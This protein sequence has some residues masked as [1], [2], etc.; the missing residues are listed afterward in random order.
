MTDSPEDPFARIRAEKGQGEPPKPAAS[1]PEG[2]PVLPVPDDA[3]PP[4]SRHSRHG[5]P[6]AIWTY[7]DGGGR[8]LGHVARFNLADGSKVVLPLTL[9]RDGRGLRWAWKA[10]A[11]PRPLYGLHALA[12]RP[13]APVLVVEGE[14]TTDAA[15]ERLA[16]FVA[17][18]WAGGSKA[19][20][21]ADWRALAG[22]DVVIWPDADAPGRKAAQD[23]ARLA[24]SA[25]ALTVVVVD[26]PAYL[27]EGWDLADEWP[28]GFGQAKAEALIAAARDQAQPAGVD[29]PYGFRMEADG[30]WYDQP[31]Q[32]GGQPVPTRLSDPF[33]V[34]G[35]AREPGGDGWATVLR[36]R[37]PDGREKVAPVA[38]SRLAGGG[39]EVRSELA[40][41]GLGISSFP[42]KAAKF[43]AAINDVKAR[44]RITLV[45]ATGWCGDRFILPSGQVGGAAGEE[46]IFTGEP[47]ALHYGR[48]GVLARWREDV[49]APAIGNDLLTFALSLAF[50]GPLM[51]PLEIEGGGVHFRGSSSC[52]KTTLAY[53]AGSVWG[54]GGPL[55]FGQTWRSTANALEMVAYGHNDGL[56]V[57]DELALIAPEEAGAA[58]Y[59]LASGQSKARSRADGSLRRRSEWRVAILST[60]EIGLADHIRAGKKGERPMAGQELRLLDLAADAGARMGVWES[61]H[62]RASPAALSDAIKAASGRDYG[63]AGPAFLEAFAA[64][65]SQHL[66][67]AKALLVAFL[68]KVTEEGDT[69]QAQ[70]AA[71]RFGAIAV[72]GELAAMFGVLPWSPGTAGEAAARL[73]R[74]W[75]SAFGRDQSHEARAI[76]RRIKAIIESEGASF[77]AWDDG[78]ALAEDEPSRAG[79]DEQAR[80][81]KSWGYR[82]KVG[83]DLEFRFNEAGWEYA[84]QG[85]GQKEAARALHEAGLLEKGE[86]EHWKKRHSRKGQ[87]PRFWTVKG[88]ILEADLGD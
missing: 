38:K 49:A 10:F 17:V 40:G 66:A 59:S 60:G 74:R 37:D 77:A 85:F 28:E 18:S 25:G 56:V 61:L 29:W 71:V 42:S 46:V 72:A 62:G 30:L 34:V 16:G 58:A 2:V 51:R 70:R 88:A 67:T 3:P 9:T 1:K 52:G 32:A 13:G 75:A 78:E 19:V 5:E 69:G 23:V 22:R 31:P 63:H 55:G 76:I 44:R 27:P 14:K 41:L 8:T 47:A 7:R 12:S 83:P 20:N 6:A 86:G 45:S 35:Q 50:L 73:Y 15:G 48:A 53:A 24:A 68:A 11:D 64:N 43:I 87:K 81:L 65:R 36:F 57:F 21:K 39:A 84:T 4:L 54:G 80:G 79:R 26:P 33:E 82:A